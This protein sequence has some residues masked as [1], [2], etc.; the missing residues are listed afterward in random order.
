M[1]QTVTIPQG[2]QIDPDVPTETVP[3]PSGAEIDNPATI[4]AIPPPRSVPEAI[5]RWA[6]NV[7][8]DIENGTD[9]TDVGKV[10]KSAGAEGVYKGNSKAVGDYMASIPLGLLKVIQGGAQ[11]RQ[12]HP[13]TGAA[14][15]TKG[16]LQTFELPGAFVAPEAEET[17]PGVIDAATQ[18]G[19]ELH[20]DVA[21]LLANGKQGLSRAAQNAKSFFSLRDV[22][23]QESSQLANVT[24]KLKQDLEAAQNGFHTNL[25][26]VLNDAAG[27]SGLPPSKAA[28]LRD[29]AAEHGTAL[30]KQARQLYQ[31]LDKAIGGTR[32][33]TYDDQIYNAVNAL[34]HDAGLNPDATGALVEHIN[35][36]EKAKSDAE[37]LALENGVDPNIIKTANAAHRKA[38]AFYDLSDKIRQSASGLRPELI[39]AKSV[40]SEVISPAKLAPKIHQLY[41][42]TRLQQA[43]GND[44]ADDLLRAIEETKQNALDLKN[45]TALQKQAI[46][47]QTADQIRKIQTRRFIAGSLAGG[48]GATTAWDWLLHLTGEH[49]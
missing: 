18:A 15:T 2:A 33:Q 10:L 38:M 19:K 25:R 7:Q 20:Q 45:N 21:D 40:G 37:E 13:L 36:L 42:T 1:A 35:A 43:L 49:K 30:R 46:Q 5:E 17:A 12:G 23:N 24:A 3:V 6:K 34:R 26:N 22:H 29:V 16:A 28:S 9:I 11:I 27:D 48:V 31:T 47:Q 32:F 14:T 41:N 39:G 8:S 44:R 4:S